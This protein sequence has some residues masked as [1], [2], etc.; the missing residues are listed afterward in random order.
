MVILKVTLFLEEHKG[1]GEGEEK[2]LSSSS[3]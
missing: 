3:E 1:L 2:S